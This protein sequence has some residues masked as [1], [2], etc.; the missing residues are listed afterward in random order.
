[1]I[2]VCLLLIMSCSKTSYILIINLKHAMFFQLHGQVKLFMG[3]FL[4][5]T[6][7]NGDKITK[8]Q[9]DVLQF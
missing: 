9:I 8:N 7:C 4:F 6:D 5:F 3:M 1:M 2:L